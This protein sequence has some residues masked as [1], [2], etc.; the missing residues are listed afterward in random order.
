MT[1]FAVE[2]RGVFA[3][4]VLIRAAA[5]LGCSQSGAQKHPSLVAGPL[6]R[7]TLAS[8]DGAKGA[9]CAWVC[10]RSLAFG[11]GW[12]S[13]TGSGGRHQGMREVHRLWMRDLG[14]VVALNED[15]GPAPGLRPGFSEKTCPSS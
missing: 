8:G 13:D 11:Y 15:D 3:G 6:T 14:S 9:G 12:P 5:V 1:L 10:P 4:A 7:R 2:P